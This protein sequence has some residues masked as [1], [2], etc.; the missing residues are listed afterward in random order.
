MMQRHFIALSLLLAFSSVA[1][2]AGKPKKT[3]ATKPKILAGFCTGKKLADACGP[4]NFNLGS[5]VERNKKGELKCQLEKD[6][7]TKDETGKTA[8]IQAAAAGDLK[9][10]RTLL[11][12]GA[13]FD[14]TDNDG[15]K[16]LD[17]AKALLE[18]FNSQTNDLANRAQTVAE[19]KVRVARKKNLNKIVELLSGPKVSPAILKT[20]TDIV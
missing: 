1:W 5:C 18:Q 2:S 12:A 7:N 15:K 19:I 10:L 14:V 6:I 13:S 9:T 11:K 17:Y 8:L 16:A 4:T 20:V 3:K